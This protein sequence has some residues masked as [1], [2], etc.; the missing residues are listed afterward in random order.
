[1]YACMIFKYFFR[2]KHGAARNSTPV[3]IF[4][5]KFIL[6]E[7]IDAVG[8]YD[9]SFIELIFFWSASGCR[10]QRTILRRTAVSK[11]H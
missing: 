2:V 7:P 5:N 1:M 10:V 3:V 8:F 9:G 11:G 4:R 6:H